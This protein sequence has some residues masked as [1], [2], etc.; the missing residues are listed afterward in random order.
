MDY[1]QSYFI[2]YYL[3]L[4]LLKVDFSSM[5]NSVENRSPILSKNIINFS[6]DLRSEEN[7]RFFKN[8][9]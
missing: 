1:A 2:K 8:R 7:F 4:I 5:I 9:F 6:I 3:P